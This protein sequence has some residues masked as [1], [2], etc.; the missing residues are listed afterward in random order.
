MGIDDGG[1]IVGYAIYSFPYVLEAGEINVQNIIKKKMELRS[2]LRSTR[3]SKLGSRKNR[4]DNRKSGISPCL[5]CGKNSKK[6]KDFCSLCDKL[7]SPQKKSIIRENPNFYAL[8]APSIKAKKDCVIRVAKKLKEKF[9]IEQAI[10][11]VAKFDFQK[12]RNP[13]IS[14][15][16]YQ[17]GKGYGYHT[18]KQALSFLYGYKCAYCREEEGK[19]QVE[20]IKP[21]GQG[22]TD[23]WE[24]LC[25][26]CPDCNKKKGNRTPKQAKMKIH[27]KIKKLQSFIFAAHVQAGKTYLVQELR[28][29]FGRDNVKIT[30]GSWTSYYRKV[31]NIEK[32]HA[33]DAIVLASMNFKGEKI[34]IDTAKTLCYKIKPLTSKAK[35]KYKAS[36]YPLS[37]KL[38]NQFVKVNNR[39]RKKVVV[40]N[41]I[42]DRITGQILYRG[43][44][45]KL[46][47]ITG[48]INKILSSG[49]IGILISSNGT[50][51]EKTRIPKNV[52]VLSRERIV[53]E[54]CG[55]L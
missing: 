4:F 46:D 21:R 8:P 2:Q 55:K 40:N 7:L 11:E 36:L 22:G 51:E 24:N 30:T 35:Q 12:L 50:K 54:P 9:G 25:L 41:S 17:Q 29:I 47:G 3:R 5:Y 33:N 52:E 18:I 31:Y 43:D 32:S 39:I 42:K 10:V 37:Q 49:S 38:N 15:E 53:F 20:H 13:E 6:Q 28:K 14:G 27:I 26:S 19:L 23:R 16:E 34:K 45:I 48:R 44:L 1:K